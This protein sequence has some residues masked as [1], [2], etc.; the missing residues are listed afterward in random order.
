MPVTV[1]NKTGLSTALSLLWLSVDLPASGINPFLYLAMM[2]PECFQA[3]EIGITM[4]MVKERIF[5]IGR[6]SCTQVVKHVVNFF[7]YVS[8]LPL[9]FILLSALLFKILSHV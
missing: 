2:L 6:L 5:F 4:K 1:T 9:L 7:Q 3:V 8:S